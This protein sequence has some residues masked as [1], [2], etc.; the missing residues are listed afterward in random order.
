M[1]QTPFVFEN[2]ESG[3]NLAPNSRGLFPAMPESSPKMEARRFRISGRV[4]GVGFRWF[5]Y[6]WATQ[7]QLKG[8][9]LNLPD[10]DV[11]VYAVGSAS[12]L[13]QLG[14]KLQRGPTM[15]R[16]AHLDEVDVDV[17]ADYRSFQIEGS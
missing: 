13:R 16:V 2:L 6:H 15:A 4:Q 3:P 17:D 1:V 5:V 12:E 7:F 14:E 9:V 11:E 10:G 8:Y